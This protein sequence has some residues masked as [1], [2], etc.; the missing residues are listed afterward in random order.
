MV[1]TTRRH[2]RIIRAAVPGQRWDLS[3]GRLLLANRLQRKK[4]VPLIIHFHGDAWLAEQSTSRHAVLAVELGAGSSRYAAP[5]IESGRFLAL[6]DEAERAAGRRFA[7]VFLSAFSAGYG[8]VRQIL[9]DP[10]SRSRIQ[11][12]LLAD[13][14]HAGYGSEAA[15]LDS[16]LQ[17]ATDAAA[18]RLRFILTHAELFPAT[19]AST[20]ETA[21]RLLDHLKL[22]RKA[23]LRWGPLGMQQLSTALRGKFLLLGFAGNSAPDHVDHLHALSHWW[24]HLKP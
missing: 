14:L 5:F 22:R 12:V 8:A 11:G 6:L 16:L 4:T 9:R 21:D 23:V 3:I 24:K 17:L 2:D 13:S 15:D 18:G 1:E 10:A 7:P 19:Y 20:T